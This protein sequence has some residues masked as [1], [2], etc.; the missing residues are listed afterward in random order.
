MKAMMDFVAKHG[1]RPQ[2]EKF[3][4]TQKGVTDAMQKLKDG[5][6]RYRGVV[7]VEGAQ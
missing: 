2:I 1:I 4:M 5:K 6:M 3:P 7:V